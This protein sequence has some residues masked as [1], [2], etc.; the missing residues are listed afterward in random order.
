MSAPDTD[1]PDDNQVQEFLVRCCWLLVLFSL[2]AVGCFGAWLGVREY[3]RNEAL[4]EAK[5]ANVRVNLTWYSTTDPTF[6]WRGPVADGVYVGGEHDGKKVRVEQVTDRV[7]VGEVAKVIYA[8]SNPQIAQSAYAPVGRWLDYAPWV[9][10]AFAVV[11]LPGAGERLHNSFLPAH[12]RRTLREVHARRRDFHHSRDLPDA[13]DS[14]DVMSISHE[15]RA[16]QHAAGRRAAADGPVAVV[17]DTPS[18]GSLPV[19]SPLAGASGADR[20]RGVAPTP[21][22]PTGRKRPVLTGLPDG[23]AKD[24]T[25][26]DQQALLAPTLTSSQTRVAPV[27]RS[28]TPENPAPPAAGSSDPNYG[29]QPGYGGQSQQGAQPHHGAQ[30]QQP[31]YGSQSAPAGQTGQAAGW[32]VSAV[33]SLRGAA[34]VPAEHNPHLTNPGHSTGSGHPASPGHATSPGHP[35]TP[36]QPMRPEVATPGYVGQSYTSTDSEPTVLV[37]GPLRDRSEMTEATSQQWPSTAT[38]RFGA[39]DTRVPPVSGGQHVTPTPGRGMWAEMPGADSTTSRFDHTAAAAYD[40]GVDNTPTRGYFTESTPSGPAAQPAQPTERLAVD[41]TVQNHAIQGEQ[42]PGSQN[43]SGQPQSPQRPASAAPQTEFHPFVVDLPGGS[44]QAAAKT[45]VDLTDH[46]A[47][48]SHS[49]STH[50]AQAPGGGRLRPHDP[51]ER[52]TAA[53]I[54]TTGNHQVLSLDADDALSEEESTEVRRLRSRSRR[55]KH[56]APRSWS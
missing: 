17:G 3:Q 16:D 1:T 11:F 42:N 40:Q 18:T 10:V 14:G 32:D 27:V 13:A 39:D 6:K 2:V 23:G 33:D 4:K 30:P 8:A 41:P 55:S 26:T 25:M 43:H 5:P 51:Q 31:G 34:G 38:W 35:A 53:P 36:G 54:H 52:V 21:V 24:P 49:S 29:V 44:G 50:G 20:S 46:A 37:E 47:Q 28:L 9:L 12:R 48:A 7:R 45:T 15:G 19:A 22:T 56:K